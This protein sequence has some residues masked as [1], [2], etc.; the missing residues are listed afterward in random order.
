MHVE[1]AIRKRRSIR[2]FSQKKVERRDIERLIDAARLAP[3]SGNSQPLV[4]LLVDDKETLDRVFSTLSWAKFLGGKGAPPKNK[5][6]T[7]YIIV[8]VDTTI[9]TK[10]FR[11]DVGFAVENMLLLATELGIGSCCIGSVERARLRK[12][13][14]VSDQFIIDIVVALGYSAEESQ[15]E[16]M[17]DSI[18]YWKDDDGVVHVPKRRLE[19]IIHW[20]TM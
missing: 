1:R 12:L 6:P 7:A 11:R 13:L 2:R 15:V 4:Y 5:K 19:D 9:T 17:K 14:N 10:N 3:S 18:K 20:N 16:E 8:M